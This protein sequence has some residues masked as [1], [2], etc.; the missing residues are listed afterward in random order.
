MGRGKKANKPSKETK[1]INFQNQEQSPT[2]TCTA[3]GTPGQSDRVQP[4]PKF[5][6]AIEKIYNK[7]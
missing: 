5:P 3:Q 6:K 7:P 1:I 2:L 4:L